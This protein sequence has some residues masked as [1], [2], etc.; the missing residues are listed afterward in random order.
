LF[1]FRAS[2]AAVLALGR[3]LRHTHLDT[4]T[5]LLATFLPFAPGELAMHRAFGTK[6]ILKLLK[7]G[8]ALTAFG[9]GN[10]DRPE[11]LLPALPALGVAFAPGTPLAHFAVNRLHDSR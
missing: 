3:D 1:E 4:S 11:A 9:I 2:F 5:A 7:N 10:G 6:A 8:A